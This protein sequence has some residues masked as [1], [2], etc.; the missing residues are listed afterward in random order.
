[1]VI[2]RFKY[3]ILSFLLALFSANISIAEDLDPYKVKIAI[4]D[5]QNVLEQS[6]AVQ[7]MQQQIAKMGEDIE[8]MMVSKEKELKNDEEEI[9]KKRQSLSEKEFEKEVD[10][11]NKKLSDVQLILQEKKTKLERAHVE[12]MEQVQEVTMSIVKAIAEEKKLNLVLPSSQVFFATDDLNIT[13]IVIS[14][15][16][17]KLKTIPIKY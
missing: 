8:H 10:L 4:V 3:I 11:F 13:K 14:R 9:A 17:Q 15:L 12:A 5:I 6:T 7:L 1:M 16:N 2:M